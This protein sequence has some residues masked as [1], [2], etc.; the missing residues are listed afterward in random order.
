[1]TSTVS[2]IPSQAPSETPVIAPSDEEV[3][4]KPT[5]LS[6]SSGGRLWRWLR[7]TRRHWFNGLTV[8]GGLFGVCFLGYGFFQDSN[9]QMVGG[10]VI[11]TMAALTDAVVYGERFLGKPGKSLE[12]A[13]KQLSML[14]K[15]LEDL[16][17]DY[18]QVGDRLVEKS[19]IIEALPQEYR[20]IFLKNAATKKEIE[21]EVQELIE[22]TQ[23]RAQLL[24][25]VEARNKQLENQIAA[26]Q[27]EIHKITE[28]KASFK[29]GIQGLARNVKQLTG[30]NQAADDIE[31]QLQTIDDKTDSLEDLT[32]DLRKA[33]EGLQDLVGLFTRL[34]QSIEDEKKALDSLRKAYEAEQG[35]VQGLIASQKDR[36]AV[37]ENLLEE[38]KRQ[39]SLNEDLNEKNACLSQRVDELSSR[40]TE[41]LSTL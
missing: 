24:E 17:Q 38:E 4:S 9:S 35:E 37:L 40:L 33:R 36:I 11:I 6:A 28:V 32:E 29:N 30:F 1:M 22:I 31:A 25:D 27:G 19:K 7:I 41:I 26:L 14:H 23:K 12:E 21:E 10:G 8:P 15:E 20:Q 13:R 3:H 18:Q 16:R 39:S 5:D 34:L 2:S